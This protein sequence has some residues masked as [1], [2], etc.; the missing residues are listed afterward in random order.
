MSR[1]PTL[2]VLAIAAAIGTALSWW[3]SADRDRAV[4][5]AAP[6]RIIAFAPNLNEAAFVLGHGEKIVAIT[7]F[8]VWPPSLLG[9]PRIGG[10]IDPNLERI[11][12]LTPDL[13]IV[14]GEAASLRELAASQGFRV[15]EVK[16]D[17]EISSI[18]S[19]IHEL[20]ELLGGDASRAQTVVDSISA[21]LDDVR[22]RA[23]GRSRPRVIFSLGHE[24]ESLDGLYTV[25]GGTFLSELLQIAGAENVFAS[26]RAGYFL[27][28]LES[29]V[30][31]APDIAI[32]LRPGEQMDEAGLAALTRLWGAV[33][34]P[35]PRVA[36][37]TFDG[38]MIPGPRIVETAQQLAAIVANEP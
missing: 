21:G 34:S 23:E 6:S 10:M 31:E 32:E 9:R 16:M 17:D 22:A 26:N 18:L 4:S 30:S 25:G 1:Q 14:Q 20:H 24:P 8:C 38:A 19:G 15:A 33:V 2:L 36:V 29:L 35:A 11:A 37:I 27:L 5:D 12:A 13:L 3:L 28:S 7:D